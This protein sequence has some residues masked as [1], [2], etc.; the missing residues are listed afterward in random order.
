MI[1]KTHTH[2][3]FSTDYLFSK[4][5]KLIEAW[6]G[7]WEATNWCHYPLSVF[8]CIRSLGHPSY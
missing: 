7:P 4:E 2:T 8:S 1:H 3:D 5:L 6:E